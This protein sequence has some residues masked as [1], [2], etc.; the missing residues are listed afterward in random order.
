MEIRQITE[1]KKNFLE[2]LLVADEQEDMIDRYLD[3]G[4]MFVLYDDDDVRGLCVVTDE[5]EG[6]FELKNLAVSPAY[7]RRGY[8][9]RLV[10]FISNRYRGRGDVLLVGTGDVPSTMV[11]Y[12]SCGFVISHTIPRFFTENYDHPIIEEGVQLVDMIYSQTT[13]KANRNMIE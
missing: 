8:G 9:K 4:E 2:L 10:E 3:R 11:F 13:I 12:Q 1:N 6:R 7:Q 5:G